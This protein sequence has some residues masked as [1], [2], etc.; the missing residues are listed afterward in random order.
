MHSSGHSL[1]WWMVLC[2]GPVSDTI[3]VPAFPQVLR[4]LT[5]SLCHD[6]PAGDTTDTRRDTCTLYDRGEHGTRLNT[7]RKALQG[8]CYLPEIQ[9]TKANEG[10]THKHPNRTTIALHPGC[11]CTHKEQ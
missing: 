2:V 1:T 3:M 5:L 7:C 9:V 11:A 6:S 10:T 8:V 4:Q